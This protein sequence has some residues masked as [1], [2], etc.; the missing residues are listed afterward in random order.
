[1]RLS[2]S[3]GHFSRIRKC[4]TIS[5]TSSFESIF[6]LDFSPNQ[7]TKDRSFI[8]HKRSIGYEDDDIV[9]LHWHTYKYVPSDV[10]VCVGGRTRVR[11]RNWKRFDKI[12]RVSGPF[13]IFH[14]FDFSLPA[15]PS[16]ERLPHRHWSCRPHTTHILDSI[17]KKKERKNVVNDE[18][19]REKYQ[20]DDD[21]MNNTSYHVVKP[22]TWCPNVRM[23][24]EDPFL[25]WK[26]FK[27]FVRSECGMRMHIH[28]TWIINDNSL[29]SCEATHLR[30]NE[31]W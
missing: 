21:L 24:L 6:E 19:K 29:Y 12:L 27:K 10:R 14:A 7:Q 17:W 5:L 23:L 1:M 4:E 30:N 20:M 8:F 3:N 31:D 28:T 13:I 16:S 2:V 25:L 15:C 26:S 9:T 11:A 22:H 18:K